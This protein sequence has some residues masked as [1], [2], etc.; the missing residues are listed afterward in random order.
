MTSLFVW[1]L[2]ARLVCGLTQCRGHRD[3]HFNATVLVFS[4]LMFGIGVCRNLDCP[5]HQI[6]EKQVV[7]C[8]DTPLLVSRQSGIELQPG[9]SGQKLRCG[10]K[11]SG[12]SEE[13]HVH[14]I[15]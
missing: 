9:F 14:S 13:A 15:W 10:L 12:K 2:L 3:T 7:P 4:A 5:A 11:F 1:S 6:G 8:P